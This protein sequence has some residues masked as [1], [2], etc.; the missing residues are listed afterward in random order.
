[1][2]AQLQVP[3]YYR[4]ECATVPCPACGAVR[5]ELCRGVNVAHYKGSGH[6]DRKSAFRAWAHRNKAKYEALKT[7]AWN[8]RIVPEPKCNELYMGEN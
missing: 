6:T 7:Q 3:D 2:P 4:M 5:G 8:T 1:M